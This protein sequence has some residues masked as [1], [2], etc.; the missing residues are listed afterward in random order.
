MAARE[1]KLSERC[2]QLERECAQL[3]L[4]VV[5]P[6]MAEHT[7]GMSRSRMSLD[8]APFGELSALNQQIRSMQE[9]LTACYKRN[10]ENAAELI[11]LNQLKTKLTEQVKHSEDAISNLKTTLE[12]K[13]AETEKDSHEKDTTVAVLR[14]ELVSLQVEYVHM[15]EANKKLKAENVLVVDRWLRKLSEEAEH[16]NETNQL[17]A[18]MKEMERPAQ[19]SPPPP[20]PKAAQFVRPA[21]MLD[22]G[23]HADF[24]S[25]RIP[26]GP[27]KILEGHQG[28]VNCVAYNVTGSVL[29]TGSND[30]TV[31]LWDCGSG[32]AKATLSGAMQGLTSVA[33]SANDENV[34]GCSNDNIAR[35]WSVQN[36]RLRHT[37]TGHVGKV[38][39]GTF[40]E[41]AAKVVTGSHDRTM[42]LWDLGKGYCIRTLFCLSSCN[43]L[44]P[45]NA[46][47]M[48]L[49]AHVDKSLRCW[50]LRNAQCEHIIDNLHGNQVTSVCVS[51]DS[52]HILTCGRDHEL[53]LVDINTFRVLSTF[54]NDEFRCGT[55]WT[56]AV[57]SPDSHYVASASANGAIFVWNTY[58]GKL[59]ATLP[60]RT[61]QSIGSAIAWSPSGF[62]V[63]TSDKH[64][65][66]L[67]E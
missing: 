29:V 8:A 58:S 32:A 16:M 1:Q 62:Q 49:S 7:Q 3:K 42:K 59:E 40:V 20:A 13:T 5:M 11:E 24:V 50:D 52:K 2:A 66:V 44:C 41:N 35:I 39:C 4:G 37:L 27:K 19:P 28:D 56:K 25:V 26:A 14:S 61:T 48:I 67:W 21:S 65:A 22:V 15:E 46:A 10:S 23:R 47:N 34:L 9:E 54:K 17:F 60:P 63:A 6:D 45:G 30:K 36:G 38:F 64:V 12:S 57:F 55:N 51:P 18:S 53:H 33:I 43:D 31:R